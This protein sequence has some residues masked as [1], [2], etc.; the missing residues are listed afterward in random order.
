MT[1]KVVSAQGVTFFRKANGTKEK[2]NRYIFRDLNL[3]IFEGDRIALIGANGAGKSTLLRLL[4]GVFLP[5]AGM[6]DS[7]TKS[8]AILDLGFGLDQELTGREN[9]RTMLI[10]DGIQKEKRSGVLSDIYEFSELGEYFDKPI[11]TY[12]SGMMVRLVMSVQLMTS[13]KCGLII[14]EG[15]GTADAAFQAKTFAYVENLIRDSKYMVF[16]SH[17]EF[18]IKSYCT[19]GIVI[20]DSAIA[21]DG[22]VEDAF[23]FYHSNI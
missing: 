9:A 18:L 20:V 14:D 22:L 6:I 8:K 5:D 19:R 1:C 3:D 4:A 10:L 11:K 12:S 16:A 13:E 15:F 2:T 23:N 7:T 21:Y 17:N